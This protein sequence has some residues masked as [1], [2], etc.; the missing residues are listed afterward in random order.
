LLEKEDMD[1]D[2]VWQKRLEENSSPEEEQKV[3]KEYLP[4]L[5]PNN[6]QI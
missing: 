4:N 1:S 3:E 6:D 5:G 2:R